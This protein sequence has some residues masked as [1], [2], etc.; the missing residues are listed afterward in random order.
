MS[1][2]EEIEKIEK[3]E[4]NIEEAK[5]AQF[6]E[7]Y[8]DVRFSRLYRRMST[9]VDYIDGMDKKEKKGT[10]SVDKETRKGMGMGRK[11]GDV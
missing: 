10:I 4:R 5:R 1:L 7:Q 11:V 6:V 8:I 3:E 2:K 9:I